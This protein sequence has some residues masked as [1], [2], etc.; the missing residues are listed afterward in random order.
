MV[1]V[2]ICI[3]CIVLLVYA[4]YSL[5]FLLKSVRVPGINYF[6]Y[7]KSIYVT[8]LTWCVAGAGADV[9]GVALVRCHCFTSTVAVVLAWKVI[10]LAYD[11]GKEAPEN[12][13]QAEGR[14][15]SVPPYIWGYFMRTP[16][17]FELPPEP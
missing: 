1:L 15:I 17:L 16:S 13:Q 5:F 4:L 12:T 8:P 6:Q 7:V 10:R 3:I 2:C 11:A 9:L 14:S